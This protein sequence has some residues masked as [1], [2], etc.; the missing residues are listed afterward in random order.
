MGRRVVIR[1]PKKDVLERLLPEE[2]ALGKSVASHRL[3]EFRDPRTMTLDEIDAEAKMLARI[4]GAFQLEGGSPEYAKILDRLEHL[5]KIFEWKRR[6]E[7]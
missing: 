5:K 7:I 4:Q 3:S 2:Q 6:G 1:K